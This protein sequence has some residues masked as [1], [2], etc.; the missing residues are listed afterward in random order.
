MVPPIDF[1][2]L[3]TAIRG[4][5]HRQGSD[6]H[7]GSHGA[8][9]RET[10]RTARR[11]CLLGRTIDNTEKKLVLLTFSLVFE[12]FTLLEPRISDTKPI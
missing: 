11:S 12:W 9:V 5:P 3:N 8:Y 2:D 7:G 10:A 4:Q 6:L 1:H